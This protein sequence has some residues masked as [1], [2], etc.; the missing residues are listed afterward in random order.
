MLNPRSLAQRNLLRHLTFALPSGQRV[1]KAMSLPILSKGDLSRLAPHGMDDRTPLWFY[2]LREAELVE[3]G[4]RLGPVGARIVAEVFLG[5]I[6][7]DKLSYLAQEP[8]WE[9]SFPTIDASRAGEDFRIVDM[10]RFAGVA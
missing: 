9:P 10:L 4:E 2:I 5:L 7:G 6:E 3:D 1:A 8:D